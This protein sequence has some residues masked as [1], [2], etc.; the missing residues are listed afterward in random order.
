ML[1]VGVGVG[2]GRLARLNPKAKARV[3]WSARQ[4]TR[5]TGMSS[6][7]WKSRDHRLDSGRGWICRET[8]IRGRATPEDCE[9]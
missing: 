3:R 2:V 5:A 7:R 1:G 6:A 4:G 9:I 8:A